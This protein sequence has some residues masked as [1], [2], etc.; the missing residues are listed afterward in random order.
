MVG[1]VT[2]CGSR[3]EG[4]YVDIQTTVNPTPGAQDGGMVM[5]VTAKVG[6]LGWQLTENMFAI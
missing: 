4:K 6:K 5:P 3:L 1:S 2:A